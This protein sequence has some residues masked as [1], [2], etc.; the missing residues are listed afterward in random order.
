MRNQEGI[1]RFLA[2]LGM[3]DRRAIG[4]SG[5]MA[6]RRSL[7]GKKGASPGKESVNEK[8]RCRRAK[9]VCSEP[10]PMSGKE[11]A[12]PVIQSVSEAGAKNLAR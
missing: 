1:K 6:T 8:K 10:V 12:S 3:T 7:S 9:K 2:L 11:G 5:R 4:G